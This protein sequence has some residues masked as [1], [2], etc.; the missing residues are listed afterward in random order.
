[1]E[2]VCGMVKGKMKGRFI[3]IMRELKSTGYNVKAKLMNAQRYEVPQSRERMI[4]YWAKEG[5]PNSRPLRGSRSAC[6]K[7]SPA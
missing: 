4:F 1:M 2:N 3:E 6:G 5:D 7:P